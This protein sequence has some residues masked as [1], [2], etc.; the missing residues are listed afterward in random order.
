[1]PSINVGI[2]SGN[3]E[4]MPSISSGNTSTIAPI[5]SGNASAIEDTN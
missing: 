4:T 3:A 5:I 1:M 2:N